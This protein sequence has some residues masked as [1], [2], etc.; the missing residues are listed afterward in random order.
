MARQWFPR[1]TPLGGASRM[2]HHVR[3]DRDASVPEKWTGCGNVRGGAFRHGSR[4]RHPCIHP[5]LT[6]PIRRISGNFSISPKVFGT[7]GGAVVG[8]PSMVRLKALGGDCVRLARARAERTFPRRKSSSGGPEA[9]TECR[10]GGRRYERPARGRR[11]YRHPRFLR[12]NHRCVR[13]IRKFLAG[14]GMNLYDNAVRTWVMCA[15]STIITAHGGGRGRLFFTNAPQS[16]TR[17]YIASTR[18]R[19]RH[20]RS[21]RAG[22]PRR[23]FHGRSRA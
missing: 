11:G 15:T 18:H 16:R 2:A 9:E 6:Y 20:R 21:G 23:S 22:I 13:R 19:G 5:V 4:R 8:H 17:K 12:A 10:Q 7:R 14:R 1:S 3:T